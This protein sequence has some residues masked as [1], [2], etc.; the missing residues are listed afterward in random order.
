MERVES[1]NIKAIGYDPATKTLSVEFRSGHSANY[2]DVSPEQHADF[3]AAPSKGKHFHKHI[4]R[5]A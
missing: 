1:S 5:L 3:M 4:R 2:S